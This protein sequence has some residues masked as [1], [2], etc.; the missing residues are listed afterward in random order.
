VFLTHHD[1]DHVGAL[2]GVL[3]R[4][5]ALVIA[6]RDEVPYADGREEPVKGG[7]SV[8]VP[9]N[10]ELADGVAV[11]TEAG[12]MEVVE[13]PGHSPGHVSL[14]FPETRL[15]VAGDALTAPDGD[16]AGPSEEFTPDMVEATESVGKLAEYDV[17]RTVCYH[18]GAVEEGSDAIARIRD[19]LAE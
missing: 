12:P 10:V 11:G 4:T 7:E 2:P 1:S 13:T 8:A 18:G 9:V 17:D 14:F 5:D 6:H 16:L 3:D 19:D 15:L